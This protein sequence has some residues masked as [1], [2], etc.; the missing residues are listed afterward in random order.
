MANDQSRT[1]LGRRLVPM[2]ERL[3][4]P[5]LLREGRHGC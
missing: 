5:G 1:R 4:L 2:Y 3:R